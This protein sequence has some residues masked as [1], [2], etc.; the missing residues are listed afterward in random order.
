MLQ[1]KHI[2]QIN[3]D[4]Y[5]NERKLQSHLPTHK[6]LLLLSIC[7]TIRKITQNKQ[8]SGENTPYKC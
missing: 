3:S 7:K 4:K 6:R 1:P 8:E 5:K 2:D